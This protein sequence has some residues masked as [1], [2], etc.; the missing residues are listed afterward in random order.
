MNPLVTK[1]IT[2]VDCGSRIIKTDIGNLKYQAYY[3]R[4]KNNINIYHY[5]FS[6]TEEDDVLKFDWSA[7]DTPTDDDIQFW[8][9][10]GMP[11][12]DNMTREKMEKWKQRQDNVK[13]LMNKDNPG[14]NVDL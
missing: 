9:R 3:D 10:I 14:I 5:L 11:Y 4:D 12:I 13:A 1:Y 2:E 7:Y 6:P 8:V